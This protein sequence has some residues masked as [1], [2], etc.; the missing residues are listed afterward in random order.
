MFSK[1]KTML[2]GLML[3]APIL[4]ASPVHAQARGVGVVSVDAAIQRTSAYQT[5]EA[6]IQST[7]ATQIQQ[8]QTRAQALRAELIPLE[9]A[10]QAAQQA[11]PNA[12]T[13][14]AVV[15]TFAQRRQAADQELAPLRRPVV[16]AR[17]YAR[18][19]IFIH[20]NDALVA[21]SAASNVDMVLKPDA[22]TWLA[23][24]SIADITAA[25]TIQLNS[26]VPSV[27]AIPPAG[28]NPGD[29][30]RAAQRQASQPATTQPEGR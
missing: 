9:Q 23:S 22:I 11:S 20:F 12:Q 29:T 18:E 21:A 19:Q 28:W 26:R 2:A 25:V 24:N 4:T 30:L 8:W 27:Q 6:Q 10:A 15:T 16:L 7:Y 1:T 14:P 13:P 17:Q 5:A 3:A